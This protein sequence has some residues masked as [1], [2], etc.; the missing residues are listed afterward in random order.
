MS[1]LVI[2]TL[3]LVMAAL[4]SLAIPAAG[5]GPTDPVTIIDVHSQEAWQPLLNHAMQQLAEQNSL[6]FDQITVTNSTTASFPTL[7][8]NALELKALDNLSGA[9]LGIAVNEQGDVVDIEAL[10]TK[11]QESINT[12]Y[13]RLD[14]P[15]AEQVTTTTPDAV[16]PVIIWLKESPSAPPQR[17]PPQAPVNVMIQDDEGLPDLRWT[18]DFSD[19][20]ATPEDPSAQ[21][22]IIPQHQNDVLAAVDSNRAATVAQ[23][24]API[25]DR[26]SNIGVEK[27]QT[28]AYAPVVYATLSVTALKD[29]ADWS[30]VDRIYL[31]VINE[32]SL[33][34]VRPTIGADAVN[35]RGFNGAGVKIAQVEA[36]GG[37][38]AAG[39][40]YLS[41]TQDTR[42]V[43]DNPSSHATGVAGIIRS[44]HWPR[45]GVAK[46]VSLWAGGSCSSTTS[47]L[48][49]R[50]TAASLWGARA[51][52]LSWG[53]ERN[54]RVGAADR[55]YD[56]LVMYQARS[57][58]VA[59]GNAN[60]QGGT[61]NVQS[62]GLAYNIITVGNF[63]DNNT[64]TWSNDTMAADSSW[65]DPISTHSDREKPEVASPGVN[66]NSTTIS[67]PWTGDIG[68]GTS[69]SAPA[70]AGT[71]ALLMQR[72]TS[73][74]YW[75]ESVKAILMT[76]AVHNIEGNRR[77][78]EYDGA[79]GIVAD[80]ADDVVRG[81]SGTWGGRGYSCYNAPTYLDVATMYLVANVRTRVAIAW[82]TDPAYSNYNNRP[83]ADLDLLVIGPSG[84]VVVGSLSWDNTYEIVDFTPSTSGNYKLRVWKYRCSSSPWWLGWA[85]RRGN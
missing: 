52:N 16:I 63:N 40:P 84:N 21:L 29:V 3:V 13:G 47:Q 38:V 49:D 27:V 65:R 48:Q 72:N 1:K 34:V 66:I 2:P 25:V 83:S 4:A 36:G 24:T 42:Y 73:L 45:R 10:A 81:A 12:K 58:V 14:P 85:W 78:S 31:D 67:H 68:S 82:D 30:E 59:A 77:L 60:Y 19:Q 41:V 33:E 70:V 69:Y 39:N 61:G 32:P 35:A 26:L 23:I 5:Q 44:S 80:R 54:R 75:P 46:G 53:S 18:E 15:L 79:G 50:S 57:V 11:E 43:C 51:L 28:D 7:G 37:R 74:Q 56:N 6:S 71:V 64:I 55:F 20:L 62:P 22:S 17:L 9:V 76:T 8:I